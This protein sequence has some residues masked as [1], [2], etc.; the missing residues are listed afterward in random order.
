[1]VSGDEFS[2]DLL[3]QTCD[4]LVSSSCCCPQHFFHPF[5]PITAAN[6]LSSEGFF[7]A[8][9]KSPFIIGFEGVL[10]FQKQKEKV[11]DQRHRIS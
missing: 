1:M 11:I 2:F 5:C 3:N 6:W 4:S 9:G 7:T 10:T 8:K